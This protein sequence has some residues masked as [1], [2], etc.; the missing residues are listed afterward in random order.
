ME[1]SLKLYRQSLFKKENKTP[2][3]NFVARKYS[4]HENT[5]G[6]I[7][8]S[9]LRGRK[10][11]YLHFMMKQDETGSSCFILLPVRRSTTMLFM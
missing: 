2:C 7:S 5:L 11:P 9:G 8:I 6:A 3:V 10:A 1:I 4:Y